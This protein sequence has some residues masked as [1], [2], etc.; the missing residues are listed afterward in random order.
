MKQLI[1][2][3]SNQLVEAIRIGR[4]TKLSF[5]TKDFNQV[6]VSGLGGSGIGGSIVQEYVFDKLKIPFTVNKDYF[7]PASIN[8]TSLFIACSYSGNTEETLQA[9]GAA[10]KAKAQIV[11]ITSGGAL[12]DFA[13]KHKLNLIEIPAGMPPRSCL[14]YSL[15]QLLFVL[16]KAGLL[17]TAVEAEIQS[18]I[19]RIQKDKGLIKRQAKTLA[20]KLADKQIAIYTIAGREGLA[21][22]F[23][24]Q[25]NENSKVLSWHNVIPEMTHNEIVG[26]RKSNDNVAV[27]F[28]YH[29]DDFPKNIK[30]LQVLKKVV[31]QYNA[32]A[33]EIIIKGSNYWE[34]AFYFIHF[35]DWVSVYLADINQQDSMEV[36]V[37]DHLKKE[38][39]KK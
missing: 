12:A 4:G 24:Q 26:W 5:A 18:A 27:V 19:D 30:R 7:I 29:T 36:K 28:C 11:C 23:R 37:I 31:K 8:A 1:E 39:A 3:F 6:M 38:M 13:R 33:H 17:K 2:Q 25:L 21:I 15:V 22:R 32:N 10:Q 20:D 35:T 9:V 14:G 34:K 16:K